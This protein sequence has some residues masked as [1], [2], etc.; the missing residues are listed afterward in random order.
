[1]NRIYDCCQSAHDKSK[2]TKAIFNNIGQGIVIDSGGRDC[3]ILDCYAN[4]YYSGIGFKN[5]S[6]GAQLTGNTTEKC[7][8]GIISYKGE[9]PTISPL[10]MVEISNN[11]IIPNDGN[12]NTSAFVGTLSGPFGIAVMDS[13][14][15]ANIQNNLIYNSQDVIANQNFIGIIVSISDNVSDASQDGFV[16]TGNNFAFDNQLGTNYGQNQNQAIYI[17]SQY[18]VISV[19]IEG[20]QFDLPYTGILTNVI[21]AY[22]VHGLTI[23]GN[24]FSD[25][26]TTGKPVIKFTGFQRVNINGNM[27]GYHWGLVGYTSQAIGFTD[28][29]SGESINPTATALVYLSN[30][31]WISVVGNTQFPITANNKDS[32]YY[33]DAAASIWVNM[34]SNTLRIVNKTSTTYY[35]SVAANFSFMNNVVG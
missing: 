20:N 12:G 13:Y 4:G 11:T 33:Q 6:E 22:A 19:L 5:A 7:K 35:S 28:N 15:G 30:C 8:I 9:S 16:I 24:N 26:N 14:G 17:T 34:Q 2:N 23:C 27:F 32:V 18:N 31:Q 1:L 3:K 10:N 29:V 21:E 25:Y